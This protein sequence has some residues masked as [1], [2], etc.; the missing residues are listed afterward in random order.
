V[1]TVLAPLLPAKYKPMPHDVLAAA[2]LRSCFVAQGGTHSY[3]MIRELAG[4]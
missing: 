2:L 3:A 4:R 1:A